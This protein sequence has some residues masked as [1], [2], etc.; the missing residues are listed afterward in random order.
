MKFFR[1]RSWDLLVPSHK[2]IFSCGRKI[3]TGSNSH[4]T[5]DPFFTIKQANHSTTRLGKH[6]LDTAVYEW[7]KIPVFPSPKNKD[8]TCEKGFGS[9]WSPIRIGVPEL[10]PDIAISELF[11]TERLLP[12]TLNSLSPFSTP[13]RRSKI[14]RSFSSSLWLKSCPQGQQLANVDITPDN[15]PSFLAFS[16]CCSAK[17]KK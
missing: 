5:R 10:V 15:F 7:R 12:A 2:K 13:S 3:R 6:W 16:V 1:I 17:Q 8:V 4:L 9:A 11:E 14:I